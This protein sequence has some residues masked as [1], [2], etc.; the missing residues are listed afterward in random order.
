MSIVAL[1]Q[2]VGGGVVIFGQYC[3]PGQRHSWGMLGPQ[4]TSPADSLCH[5]GIDVIVIRTLTSKLVRKIWTT[6][7]SSDQT[8]D[9]L[10]HVH[11]Q[12][13]AITLRTKHLLFIA[14]LVAVVL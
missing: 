8:E 5:R 7:C 13:T 10:V 1:D 2:F 3:C 12:A 9:T 11:K 4:P 14:S 6:A